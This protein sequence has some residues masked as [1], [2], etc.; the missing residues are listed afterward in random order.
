GDGPCFD[1]FVRVEGEGDPS[2][3]LF[4]LLGE[5]RAELQPASAAELRAG[6]YYDKRTGFH[7][8]MISIDGLEWAAEDRC[9]VDAGFF[10]DGLAAQ[11]NL[12]Q[13]GVKGGWWAVLEVS[14]LWI[15]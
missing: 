13:V 3:Y 8:C 9:T 10:H 6:G 15:S 4:A 14:N 1:T 12:Y 5:R 2:P 7:G 11:G